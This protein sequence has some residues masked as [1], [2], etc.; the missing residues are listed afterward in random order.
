MRYHR[1]LLTVVTVVAASGCGTATGEF[2]PKD[3]LDLDV[4][5]AGLD[6]TDKRI[7]A[8][9]AYCGTRGVRLVHAEKS[10]W[11]LVDAI[12]P[13]LDVYVSV[14]SFPASANEEQMLWALASISLA[15][16]LNARSHLAMSYLYGHSRNVTPLDKKAWEEVQQRLGKE[17]ER[18]FLEYAP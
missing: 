10:E 16:R 15:C 5:N 12:V 9:V 7:L 4:V 8:F 18:L 14:R 17:L 1:L 3:P 13:N 2:R 11:L 6:P